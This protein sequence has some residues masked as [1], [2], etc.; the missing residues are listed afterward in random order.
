MARPLTRPRFRDR[1]RAALGAFRSSGFQ[2]NGHFGPSLTAGGLVNTKSGMGL[3][4]DK[5]ESS[6]FLPT[7]IYWRG[8]LEV[9]YNQ[10]WSARKFVDMPVD[11]MMEK[12]RT[13]DRENNGREAELMKAQETEF[14]VHN[15]LSLTMKA[16]RRDGTGLLCLITTE[17]PL[18]E[19]L[20]PERIR[21]GD[22]REIE[23]YS[24]YSAHVSQRDGSKAL[25][26]TI[27]PTDAAQ[28]AYRI[29]ASRVLRFDGQAPLSI[30]GYTIYDRDWGVSELIP[31]MISIMQDAS[32]ASAAAHLTQEASIPVLGVRGLREA[33][34]GVGTADPN[35][36][37]PAQIGQRINELKSVFRL[38]MLEAGSE[39]FSRVAVNFAGLDKVMQIVQQ[40]LAA[41][42]GVPY[43]R[44]FGQSPG[45]LNSTGEYD[46]KSYKMTLSSK[47][48]RMLTTSLLMPLDIVLARNAGL[49]DVP[50]YEWPSLYEMG[51]KE[52]AEIA[53]IKTEA[54]HNAL[55]DGAIDEDAYR[56]ALDGDPVFGN[57][58]EGA[59]PGLDSL[60]PDLPPLP[61]GDGPP[62]AE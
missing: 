14:D 35:V 26:Y 57:L 55:H 45:G 42:A 6:Y 5:G 28:N 16:A 34:A 19:P 40:R 43:T 59:A 13:W 39:E 52:Q 21:P 58:P 41:A 23:F 8:E 17:A 3:A 49:R 54:L 62:D 25:E 10:S 12:P 44:M 53:K 61:G 38:L 37:T 46:D 11:D 20:M 31:A 18:E 2:S 32:V 1:L 50:A 51:A 22:L 56:R 47:R 4:G 30:D 24:R 36:E 7:R 15:R 27:T 33:R 48:Q 29:H 9:L 60:T